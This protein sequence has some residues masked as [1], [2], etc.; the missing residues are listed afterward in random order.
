MPGLSV[1]DVVSV[2]II[3][4]QIAA[5]D[6]NF[7]VLLILG[8]T[9]VIDV[10][11]MYRIYT[12]SDDVIQDIGSGTPE[13]NAAIAYFAQV[14]QPEECMVGRWASTNTAG[15][16]RGAILGGAQLSMTQFNTINNGSLSIQIDGQARALTGMDFTQTTNFN[17]VAAILSTGLNGVAGVTWDD[18]NNRFIIES[19]TTGTLSSVNYATVAGTG[20]DISSQL[21]FQNGSGAY[22]VPGINAQTIAAAVAKFADKTQDWYGL[23]IAATAMPSDN[24]MV[25]V[26]AFIESAKPS[27]LLGCTTQNPATLDSATNTDLASLMKAANYNRTFTQYSSFNAFAAASFFGRAFTVDFSGTDTMLTMDFQ[28][29]PGIQAETVTESQRQVLI[30]KRCNAFLA[31]N[32]NTS[33]LQEGWMASGQWFD[34]IYGADWLQNDVQTNIW[35]AFITAGTRVSGDETGMNTLLLASATSGETGATNGLLYRNGVWTGVSIGSIIKTGDTLPKGYEVFAGPVS[36]QTV[37]QRQARI[38]PLIQMPVKF[39]GAFHSANVNIV[40]NQ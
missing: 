3:L 7:G 29:E 17:A 13:A 28:N 8:D 15:L 6:R 21:G 19:D 30:S 26:G 34:V 14:P 4:S 32:N 31:F 22:P 16:L 20:T 27:R 25:G 38:P 35:N 18:T 11:E 5:Q 9:D 36:G 1:D 33:I 24:A 2:N 39:T 37:A 10:I 12:S 23:T 40:V